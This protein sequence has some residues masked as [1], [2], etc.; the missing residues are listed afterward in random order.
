MRMSIR[1]VVLRLLWVF[2][3]SEVRSKA[4][5]AV[6]GERTKD[7]DSYDLTDRIVTGERILGRRANLRDHFICARVMQEEWDAC[8]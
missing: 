2:L 7:V 6:S 5:L 8:D 4:V 1:H 3:N